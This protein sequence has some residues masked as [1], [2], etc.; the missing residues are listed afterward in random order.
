MSHFAVLVLSKPGQR[1]EELLLPYMENSAGEPPL[2]Y[3]EFYE[4]DECD[5]DERTGKRGYWQNPNAKWDWW[6]VGGRFSGLLRAPKGYHGRGCG[7]ADGCYDIAKMRD[8][9]TAMDESVYRAALDEF[10]RYLA[11][12]EVDRF[13]LIAY[14]PEYVLGKYRD[15][16]FYA[17]QRAE[18]WFR[19][20]VTPDGEWHEVGEMGWWGVSSETGEQLRDW[21]EHFQERFVEPYR[22]CTAT[23]VDCHI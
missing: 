16:E 8:V 4:D 15:A 6:R 20:V 12:D 9:S 23:V 18:F 2:E 3:M 11:G 17:R 22:D 1:V 21:V 13:D 10:N 19:S 14:K 7:F 5:V